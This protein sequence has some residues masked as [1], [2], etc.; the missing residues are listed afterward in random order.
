MHFLLYH[1]HNAYQMAADKKEMEEIC[2]GFNI[3]NVAEA[4]SDLLLP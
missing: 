3:S 4:A 2:S 1:R